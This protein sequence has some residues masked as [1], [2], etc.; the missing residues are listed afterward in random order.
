MKII[1]TAPTVF[2]IAPII[3]TL[4]EQA[5]KLSFS[6]YSYNGH[7]LEVL[8]TGIGSVRTAIAM[9]QLNTMNKIDLAIQVGVAGSYDRSIRLGSVVLVTKDRF[10][11]IGVEEQDGTFTSAETLGLEDGNQYPYTDGWIHYNLKKH[12]FDNQEVRGITVNTVSGTTKTIQQRKSLYNPHIE[13]MEGAAFYYAC[14]VLDIE[15]I[16][17]R[18][19]SNYVEPRNKDNW[20]IDQAIENLEKEFFRILPILSQI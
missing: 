14:R 19:I 16:Q 17:M 5:T 8:V 1:I 18:A 9:V 7:E 4:D 11:D 12:Q 20:R 2:E 15:C 13:S 3:K 10:G 6:K